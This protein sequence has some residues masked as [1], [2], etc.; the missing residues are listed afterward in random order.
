[1]ARRKE[2][3]SV[4]YEARMSTSGRAAATAASTRG[5]SGR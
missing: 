2:T 4:M 5:Q 1:M 3:P